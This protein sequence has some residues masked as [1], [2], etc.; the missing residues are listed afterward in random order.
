M[1]EKV[2]VLRKLERDISVQKL[3]KEYAA[4]LSAS[5]DKK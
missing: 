1:Q 4:D 5:C 3:C 2:E